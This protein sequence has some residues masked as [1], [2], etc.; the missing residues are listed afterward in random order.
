MHVFPERQ[1]CN[2]AEGG[3]GNSGS[4]EGEQEEGTSDAVAVGSRQDGALEGVS[5]FLARLRGPPQKKLLL[6]TLIQACAEV[7]N[8]NVASTTTSASAA[9]STT[10]STGATTELLNFEDLCAFI[11]GNA[12]TD[13]SLESGTEC[14]VA[15]SL[16]ASP[17]YDKLHAFFSQYAKVSSYRRRLLVPLL[18]QWLSK[19][20]GYTVIA[21][22]LLNNVIEALRDELFKISPFDTTTVKKESVD[23]DRENVVVGSVATSYESADRCYMSARQELE[24]MYRMTGSFRG[25]CLGLDVIIRNG[26]MLL[27]G[28]LRDDATKLSPQGGVTTL[29]RGARAI[30]ERAVHD[31]VCSVFDEINSFLSQCATDNKTV[32][33]EWLWLFVMALL[34]G[35]ISAVS[36]F[37]IE[38]PTDVQVGSA[39]LQSQRMY[40]EAL[41]RNWQAC[42]T[43]RLVAESAGTVVNNVSVYNMTCRQPFFWRSVVEVQVALEFVPPPMRNSLVARQWARKQANKCWGRALRITQSLVHLQQA[44]EEVPSD[45]AATA[46]ESVVAF[47]QQ[48]QLQLFEE[49]YEHLAT[50]QR[51]V[52]VSTKRRRTEVAPQSEVEDWTWL[53][54]AAEFFLC[55]YHPSCFTILSIVKQSELLSLLEEL[56]SLITGTGVEDADESLGSILLTVN[57]GPMLESEVFAWYKNCVHG[58]LLI[59]LSE[60]GL[61]SMC[62][63][64]AVFTLLD[65][66]GKTSLP[67]HEVLLSTLLPTL[68][69]ICGISSDKG[70][71]FSEVKLEAHEAAL[72]NAHGA[73]AEESTDFYERQL[74]MVLV[75]ICGFLSLPWDLCEVRKRLLLFVV[76][77]VSVKGYISLRQALEALSEMF[78]LSASGQRTP[79]QTLKAIYSQCADISVQRYIEC[80][81]SGETGAAD[82]FPYAI[83]PVQFP[84][85]CGALLLIS[86]Y[87]TLS[88][89]LMRLR[90]EWEHHVRMAVESESDYI[91]RSATFCTTDDIVTVRGL[92]QLVHRMVFGFQLQSVGLLRLWLSYLTHLFVCIVPPPTDEDELVLLHQEAGGR[93][94]AQESFPDKAAGSSQAPIHSFF[95]RSPNE[96]PQGELR[97]VLGEL[98]ADLALM[99][100]VDENEVREFPSAIPYRP[101]SAEW[102]KE[103]NRRTQDVLILQHVFPIMLLEEMCVALRI[104]VASA[105][106]NAGHYK[107]DAA[108]KTGA[109]VS[110]SFLGTVGLFAFCQR[111]ELFIV[112][113]SFENGRIVHYLQT[114]W[115]AVELA[116]AAGAT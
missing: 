7:E 107:A 82:D 11:M 17:R 4:V 80:E 92:V 97:A 79:E 20:K 40:F 54:Y 65:R 75:I 103:R 85:P 73:G 111:L 95:R 24:E 58:R 31:V 28:R 87:R 42:L 50:S 9:C 3:S 57:G 37:G 108:R 26:A 89:H 39:L 56:N 45:S 78:M 34:S 96:S 69:R 41:Q 91:G 88:K 5:D 32:F 74:C 18:Q 36:I 38:P 114:L 115:N 81:L 21:V 94:Q 63:L 2:T 105:P 13:S 72:V 112:P 84:A 116:N 110:R 61:F 30:L 8:R 49:Y 15:L 71:P 1:Q 46:V 53:T 52:F 113:D 68:A 104:N 67:V 19:G 33:S 62:L 100:L 29:G 47:I 76:I 99:S 23:S 86:V 66:A 51:E 59:V 14:T 60:E 48:R 101:G 90:T 12:P 93:V 44:V 70:G 35:Y 98:L 16:L 55:V 109:A 10:L 6:L 106:S 22:M 64:H 83:V 77:G 27:A 43:L 25:L 102:L